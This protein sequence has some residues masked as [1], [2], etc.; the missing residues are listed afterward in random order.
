MDADLSPGIARWLAE[1]SL[2]LGMA[3]QLPPPRETAIRSRHAGGGKVGF[4][5]MTAI[6]KT[7]TVQ[8]NGRLVLC[9]PE[10]KAGEIVKVI[11]LLDANHSAPPPLSAG[12]MLKQD[13]AGGLADLAPEYTSVQLQHKAGEWRGD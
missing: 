6:E 12:H 11:L 10:L 8:S 2:H 3:R 4:N 13:W 7:A 5:E 1:N 9:H